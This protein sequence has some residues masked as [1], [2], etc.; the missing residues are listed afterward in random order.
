MA[1]VLAINPPIELQAEK[2]RRVYLRKKTIMA[3]GGQTEKG[4]AL[5]RTQEQNKMIRS[6]GKNL[7]NWQTREGG[8]ARS[9]YHVFTN[10]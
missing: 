2:I 5:I 4:L 7:G 1:M 10:G 8:L 6:W 9:Y 3:E